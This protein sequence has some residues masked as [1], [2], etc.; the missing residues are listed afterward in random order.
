MELVNKLRTREKL[1]AHA[2]IHLSVT[3]LES[4]R[5]EGKFF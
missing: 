4:F 2:L 3:V 5:R 1:R